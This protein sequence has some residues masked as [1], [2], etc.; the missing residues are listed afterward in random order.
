MGSFTP[1]EMAAELLRECANNRLS[2]RLR[3]LP[4]SPHSTLAT[5]AAELISRNN[6]TV[7][8]TFSATPSTTAHRLGLS[9]LQT[10][11]QLRH[12]LAQQQQI[13]TNA[14]ISQFNDDDSLKSMFLLHKRLLMNGNSLNANQTQFQGVANGNCYAVAGNPM[15]LPSPHNLFNG[16][17][18]PPKRGGVVEPFPERLHR[19]LL[20]VEAAGRSDVIS[21]I[22]GG[23]AFAIHKPTVFF[24]DIVPHY[25]RQ[26]RLSSFKR[27]LNLYGFELI[28]T[29]AARGGYFH[30]LFR[31]DKPELCRGMRRTI[32]N[33]Q[34]KVA[35][36]ECPS[37]AVKDEAV[38][39]TAND[40]G[41]EGEEGKA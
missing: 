27:Q 18:C 13:A 22:A 1:E 15:A 25:F 32:N 28:S 7:A 33:P 10:I 31:K 21:F 24:K 9:D 34:K 20:E 17:G 8:S 2:E 19:L 16:N 39:R 29:G 38:A 23:R 26:S 14:S 5:A 36:S 40:E 37:T 35:P 3:L 41:V 12:Q 11:Q 6:N 30:Q 4:P